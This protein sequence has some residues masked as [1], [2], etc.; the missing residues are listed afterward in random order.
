M[1][2]NLDSLRALEAYLEVQFASRSAADQKQF[3]R[4]IIKLENLVSAKTRLRNQM[5]NLAETVNRARKDIDE[6]YKLNSCG[7]IQHTA[8]IEFL[9]GQVDSLEESVRTYVRELRDTYS[10]DLEAFGL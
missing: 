2:T 8:G 7:V 9:A 6:G 4:V 3:N 1:K 10:L 5:I